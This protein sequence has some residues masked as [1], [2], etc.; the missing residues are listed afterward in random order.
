MVIQEKIFSIEECIQ[1]LKIKKEDSRKW[2]SL[3]RNYNSESIS[4]S[5]KTEW[6]FDRIKTFFEKNTLHTLLNLNPII[7]FHTYDVNGDFKKHNDFINGRLYI[8]GVILNV[9]YDGGELIVYDD[10]DVCKI[11]KEIGNTFLFET[12]LNHEVTHIESG[13][14]YTIIWFIHD[15]EIFFSKKTLF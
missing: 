7:H 3:D 14:R 10:I 1:I 2:K 11:K 5:K 9:D 8:L 4:L 6:I 12:K 15:K 13:I